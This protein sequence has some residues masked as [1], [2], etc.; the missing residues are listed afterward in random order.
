M[1]PLYRCP[2]CV[3]VERGARAAAL[4]RKHI[5]NVHR[6]LLIGGL[7]LIES[8]TTRKPLDPSRIHSTALPPLNPG[9]SGEGD[10]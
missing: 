10:S 3:L 9:V 8:F 6:G 5:L 1:T 2:W 7:R 4:M